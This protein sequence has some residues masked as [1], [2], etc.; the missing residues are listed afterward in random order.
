VRAKGQRD[1]AAR[2]RQESAVHIV[3]QRGRGHL[4][5]V[6]AR[7]FLIEQPLELG[8]RHAF[9]YRIDHFDAEIGEQRRHLRQ[10]HLRPDHALARAP[11]HP[12]L[13]ANPDAAIG[14]GRIDEQNV[15]GAGWAFGEFLV[16]ERVGIRKIGS[17]NSL[18][19]HK[20]HLRL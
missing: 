15:H 10:V 6:V 11:P 13:A 18:L 9:G 14:R 7:A 2:F 20:S 1:C 12:V 3:L 4:G 16:E 8:P 19:N 17:Y 5:D